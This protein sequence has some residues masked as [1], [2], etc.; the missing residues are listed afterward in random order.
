MTDSR[1]KGAAFEN[2]FVLPIASPETYEWLRKKHYLKRLPA[3]QFCFGLY[4][5]NELVGVVTFGSPPS[6]NLCEGVCGKEYKNNVLELSRLCLLNNKKNEASFFISKA[7]KFL[8][9][10]SII[11]S[12]AD[13][14][15]GHHGFVYQACNFFYCGLSEKRKDYNS[16]G[17]HGRTSYEKGVLGR[18]R[19]RKH[20]Y[21]FICGNRKHKKDLK[22]CI[23]Y[24][25]LPYPK[26]KNTEY[27]S[28]GNLATQMVLF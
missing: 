17:K 5:K 12:Y 4:E 18:D 10:P 26:G 28:G 23:K 9:Q 7:L 15:Q 3:L 25:I 14:S 27:N 11:V 13:I 24:N 21:V 1:Q 19:P 16:N 2:F 22:K 6:K 20:R 8:P